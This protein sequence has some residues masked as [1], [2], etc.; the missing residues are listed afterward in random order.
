MCCRCAVAVAVPGVHDLRA[1]ELPVG[2]AVRAR[3]VHRQSPGPPAPGSHA[4]R[5]HRLLAPALPRALPRRARLPLP[6]STATFLPAF[7]FYAAERA[8][9]RARYMT[10]GSRPTDG[11]P[12]SCEKR[13]AAIFRG[14]RRR[15]M[16]R[17]RATGQEFICARPI[18]IRRRNNEP[19]NVFIPSPRNRRGMASFLDCRLPALLLR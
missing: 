2:E 5:Q 18:C 19:R 8:A 12:V 15:S 7:Y 17:P 16:P 9:P 11:H 1:E 13:A 10:R 6:V 4:A 3:L 14:G